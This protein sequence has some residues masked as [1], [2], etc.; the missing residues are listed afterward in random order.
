[1]S[2]SPSDSRSRLAHVDDPGDEGMFATV[3]ATPVRYAVQWD[4]AL[5]THLL[6]ES[7]MPTLSFQGIVQGNVVMLPDDVNLPNG[8]TVEVRVAVPSGERSGGPA[9]DEQVEP[10]NLRSRP[11]SLGIGASG[12]ADTARRT[13]EERPEPRPWR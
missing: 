4:R 13:A 8:A 9:S 3:C 1:M 2:G 7:S 10:N 12:L 11:K 5:V 6:V